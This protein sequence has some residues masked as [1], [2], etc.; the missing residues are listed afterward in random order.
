VADVLSHNPLNITFL[1][2]LT[3]H[4][5][6]RWLHLVLRLMEVRLM[7]DQD[8][9]KWNLTTSGVFSV[10]SMYLDFLNG[11]TKFLKR[12]IWK[13][14]VPL[15]I[16]IF[17][18]FL[19]R[20][21]ILT[22]DNLLK[23]NW[24]GNPTCVFCDKAESIQ[25]LFFDCPMAK[26]VWRL[27]HMTFGLPP[28]KSIAN[29][30]ANW[31]SN[32][33]K[34]DVKLIRIGVCAIVWALWN[35]RNDHVFNKPKASSFLQVIPMAT[36]WICTWSYLQPLEQRDVTDSGCNLWRRSHGTYSTNSA[37]GVIIGFCPL[38]I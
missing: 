5:W 19:H 8:S 3:D 37:G 32:L 11:H 30:F 22:K 21:V 20:K 10:K 9:F 27:V 23:H 35:A 15:K 6:N 2:N 31:L 16:R 24:H 36:N 25:H 1:H 28:P 17:M 12:Y 29:L 7:P 34:N 18:W 4:K 13:I 26:I 33:N 14:K 38:E